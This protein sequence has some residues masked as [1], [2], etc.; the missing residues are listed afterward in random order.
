MQQ[1]GF[2]ELSE[3]FVMA[4]AESSE[5]FI[6]VKVS[7]RCL[8]ANVESMCEAM[9]CEHGRWCVICHV[10]VM[11]EHGMLV[12]VCNVSAKRV[13]LHV[14]LAW[15]ALILVACQTCK[16]QR[17]ASTRSS[18]QLKQLCCTAFCS[19]ENKNHPHLAADKQTTCQISSTT[20]VHVN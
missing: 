20:S 16:I 18:S 2:T 7:K 11:L 10:C 12:K 1:Q 6:M 13:T 5:E 17:I 8:R 9:V 14:P 15:A 3:A 4:F 19:R